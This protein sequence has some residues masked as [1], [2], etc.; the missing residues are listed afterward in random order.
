LITYKSLTLPITHK[1]RISSKIKRIKKF[2]RFTGYFKERLPHQ[3]WF[4]LLAHKRKE[5]EEMP[6]IICNKSSTTR[7]G[8]SF[9][10]R[11]N[12]QKIKFFYNV[13]NVFVSGW[14]RKEKWIDES[15]RMSL[16]LLKSIL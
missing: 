3:L 10:R 9:R 11:L 16:Y 13:P 5:L 12:L 1:N 4:S 7:L 14:R 15:D 2:K 6:E 8:R